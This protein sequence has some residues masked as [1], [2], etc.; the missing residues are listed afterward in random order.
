MMHAQ[1]TSLETR[2]K[3]AL[4]MRA[5]ANALRTLHTAHAPVDFCSNDYLGLAQDATLKEK[6]LKK[7][8]ELHA[9]GS[10]GSRLLTG[11]HQLTET[12]EN[13]VAAFHCAEAALFFNS[14]YEANAGLV[15]SV[16]KRSDTILYD[17]CIHASLREGIKLSN[18]AAY[19]FA[20]NDVTALESRLQKAAGEIFIIL[21]SVYSMDGD[22]CP[23]H[24][25]VLLAEKYKAHIILDE[26]HA[27]GVIGEK[28]EGLAL[29]LGLHNN[30]FARVHT[31]GKAIGFN[32]A[33]ILGSKTLRSYLINFCRPFIYTTAPNLMQVIAVGEAYQHMLAF[34]GSIRQL[35][36]NC[37]FF[38]QK[39]ASVTHSVILPSDSAI[40]SILVPGNENVKLAAQHLQQ[41][42]YDIKPIVS[43]TVA[44]GK[45]RLRICMHSFNTEQQIEN[46]LQTA[47]EVILKINTK[48][49]AAKY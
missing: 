27:T 23:L 6:I 49:H 1:E 48:K 42:G 15:A 41:A 46:M 20:H 47:E 10:T 22:V 24:D 38:K 36:S 3:K 45:E 33:F 26:A 16:A 18:A 11:N 7:I 29:H 44:K 31:C 8:A 37:T 35:K 5:D 21:E 12:L 39:L 14:G 34:P 28:G 32:G 9:L 19:A 25:M 43:P 4:H 2:L 17:E 30:I 40:F 13:N